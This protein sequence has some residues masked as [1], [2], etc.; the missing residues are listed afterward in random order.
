MRAWSGKAK[1]AAATVVIGVL[2]VASTAE[3]ARG[4]PGWSWPVEGGVITPYSNDEGNPYAGGMHRGIDIAAAVGAPVRAARGGEV[5]YAGALGYSGLTVAVHTEDGYVTSYLHLSA[6]SVRRGETIG[7]GAR[8][9]ELGTS[10]RRSKPEPHLHFGVRLARPERRYVDPLSL[11][12]PLPGS[13]AGA[14]VSPA[15]AAVLAVPEPAPARTVAAP[16]RSLGARRPA[17]RPA[18]A[19]VRLPLPAPAERPAA[20]ATPA[21]RIHPV[22]V[23]P[24]P[25]R[26]RHGRA[27]SRAAPALAP[28]VPATTPD[29]GRPLAFAGL[30]LL[31]LVLFG[32]SA[33][34]VAGA[35]N[36]IVSGRA[37]EMIGRALRPARACLPRSRKALTDLTSG[38]DRVGSVP[39]SGAP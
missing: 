22:P 3:E 5:T 34:R 17:P 33:L 28:R 29:W 9:G 6:V 36:R 2:L 30:A 19:P 18:L 38:A 4:S 32:R 11:L 25:Q 39:P 21:H 23:A 7:G 10:G 1:G 16:R 31:V 37:Y 20:V 35:T 27:H 13:H 12:P 24:A 26:I 15:P 14:P 8:L